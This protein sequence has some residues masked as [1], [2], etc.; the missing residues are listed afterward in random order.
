[1][2]KRAVFTVLMLL[3]PTISLA[4]ENPVL[5]TWKLKS[6][7]REVIATGEKTKEMGE[8]PNGY[9]S[10]SADGRMYGI[11]TGTLAPSRL[12]RLRR[13]RSAQNFTRPCLRT[14]ERIRCKVKK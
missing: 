12:V 9:L 8:H 5:G 2:V 4:G 1:M 14:L 7:Y 3:C 13:M 10:Y 11:I 6:M